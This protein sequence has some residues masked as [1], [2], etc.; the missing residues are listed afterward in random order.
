MHDGIFNDLYAVQFFQ[1]EPGV[2]E[3]RY[4]PGPQF[5]TS[6]LEEIERGIRRKLGDDFQITLRAV[7]ETENRARQ[8]PVDR[9]Q[10]GL[11]SNRREDRSFTENWHEPPNQGA[12]LSGA[13]SS[14]S[15]I[16]SG[17]SHHFCAR[18]GIP[19]FP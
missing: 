11:M 3:F 10:A 8:T 5:H 15:M 9:E 12:A 18:A 13:A 16:I 7:A 1:E 14:S 6:R 17:A 4:V 2:A 19:K